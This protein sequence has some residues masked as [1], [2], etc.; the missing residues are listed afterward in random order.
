MPS[1]FFKCHRRMPRMKISSV[2]EGMWWNWALQEKALND[3]QCRRRMWGMK[4][5]N[6]SRKCEIKQACIV[7]PPLCF[8]INCHLERA[9]FDIYSNP[10]PPHT[11]SSH[12]PFPDFETDWQCLGRRG[13]WVQGEG[14]PRQRLVG[15]LTVMEKEGWGWG[16]EGWGWGEVLPRP[17]ATWSWR[18]QKLQ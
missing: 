2:G 10:P 11:H 8:C 17:H 18:D 7:P 16:D 15:L 12:L 1:S 6:R 4:L 5:S 3:N 13:D 9:G 14:R